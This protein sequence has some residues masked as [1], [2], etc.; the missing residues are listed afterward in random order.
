MK[1]KYYWLLSDGKTVKEL[2]QEE[3][4][5]KATNDMKTNTNHLFMIVWD[6]EVHFGQA[7]RGISVRRKQLDQILIP[8]SREECERLRKRGIKQ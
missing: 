8:V 7:R 4:R 1:P 3:Y 6:S 5:K 2:T